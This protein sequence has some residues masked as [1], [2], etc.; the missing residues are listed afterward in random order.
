[1]PAHAKLLVMERVL[2]E[3][4]DP[5]DPRSRANVLVDINMMLMSPGGRERTE[6]EHRRLLLEAGL[7]IERVVQT[8]SP[9]SIIQAASATS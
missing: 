3:R 5:D 1:M 6:A 2:P 7:Q 8:S 4:V 9:L